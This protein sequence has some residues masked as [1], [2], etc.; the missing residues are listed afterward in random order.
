MKPIRRERLHDTI[1]RHLALAILRGETDSWSS[2]NDL[3]RKLEVSRSVLRESIKVLASKG[4]LE[5]RPKIGIRVR[6]RSDWNLL[7]PEL[8]VW[9]FEAGMDDQLLRNLVEVRLIVETAGAGLA[10]VRAT[11]EEIA[12]L[13]DCYR[14]MEEN[15]DDREAYNAAD[16]RFHVAVFA[17]C[18]NP[19]LERMSSTLRTGLAATQKVS[20]KLH[21]DVGLPLHEAVVNAVSRRDP[22]AARVAAE[23]LI[24]QA[25]HEVYDVLHP[26]NPHGWEAISWGSVERDT[27]FEL[28]PS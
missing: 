26:D 25:A 21:A 22:A 20:S 8:L 27:P 15:T 6:P 7:D 28:V 4:L 17:A 3:C 24:L 9:Q 14:E 2:E 1:S 18:H 5:V 12:S 11:S 19:L 10:A 16:L 13:Q 23:K